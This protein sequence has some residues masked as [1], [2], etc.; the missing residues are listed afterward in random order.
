MHSMLFINPNPFAD[1]KGMTLLEVMV[2]FVIFT[3]SLVAILN[4]VSNQVFLNHISDKNQQK[5]RLVY[6]YSS[7]SELG[8]EEQAAMAASRKN[9]DLSTSS[10]SLDSY[11][12]RSSESQL[13]HTQISVWDR[14]EA[15]VWSVFE[16]K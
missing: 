15:Y 2:G 13:L 1:Q 7:I 9:L 16:V 5:A 10:S 8:A 3:S 4:F 6:D 14:G 11:K 12:N